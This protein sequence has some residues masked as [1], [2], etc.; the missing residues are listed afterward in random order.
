MND[1]F[2]IKGLLLAIL[3]VFFFDIRYTLH[4]QKIKRF[5]EAKTYLK[6]MYHYE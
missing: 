4:W 6:K 3:Y 1:M 5:H 2:I